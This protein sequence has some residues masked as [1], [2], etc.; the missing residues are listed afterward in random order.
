MRAAPWSC[1]ILMFVLSGCA[2]GGALKANEDGKNNNNG[3]ADL[4]DVEC[5]ISA[6]AALSGEP[7]LECP[8]YWHCEDVPGRTGAK[9]CFNPGPD[10]PDAT[11]DWDCRDQA[12]T[13]VCSGGEFPDNGGDGTWNCRAVDEHVECTKTASTSGPNNSGGDYPNAAH[14]APWNCYYQENFRVCESIPGAGQNWV[15]EDQG[16]YKECK[17]TNPEF[18]DDGAD[19]KWSCYDYEHQTVCT[20]PGDAP[21]N[22]DWECIPSP[23]LENQVECRQ[24]TPEYPDAGGDDK[25]NCAYYAEIKICTDNPDRDNPLTEGRND[26]I[27]SE[28]SC[29][30]A[31]VYRWCDDAVYCSWGKQVCQPDKTWGPCVEPTKTAQGFT[32]RPSTEC[33]CRYPFFN[34]KCCETADCLIPTNHTPP[35]CRPAGG[36]ASALCGFCDVDANCGGNNACVSH[37]PTS[38]SPYAGYSFCGQTCTGTGRGSC[39][40]NYQCSEVRG[41]GGTQS[42]QCTPL[43]GFCE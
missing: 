33:A 9:R 29:P 39:P 14:D 13:I 38:G 40:V 25:W 10:L 43:G 4:P 11:Q 1:L 2:C 18:P 32:D 26:S 7:V 23:D 19:G 5:P 21:T 17:L 30:T 24:R 31:G 28:T 36:G 22:T 42:R 35:S 16:Q 37:D 12:G 34:A 6:D 8:A 15:C 27:S 41:Q 3:P 20:R